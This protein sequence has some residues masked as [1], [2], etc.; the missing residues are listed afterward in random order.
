MKYT[1]IELIT[2]L[3]RQAAMKHAV[4]PSVMLKELLPLCD[5]Y[6]QLRA[7]ALRTIAENGHLADGDDC[8]LIHLKR[9]VQ[10]PLPPTAEPK[11]KATKWRGTL[12]LSR[13]LQDIARN[14]DAAI[15][16]AAGERV[17]FTLIVF[18][19]GRASYISSAAREESAREIKHLLDIWEQGMPDVPAHEYA[20]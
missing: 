2:E 12:N 11:A 18:T 17:A 1:K 15:E 13:N 10:N 4:W 9:A 5:D 19:E 14:L 20:G 3:R 6:E 16:L 8:T 7:A